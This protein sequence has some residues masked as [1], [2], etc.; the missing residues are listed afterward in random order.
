MPWETFWA[1]R[2]LRWAWEPLNSVVAW[3]LAVAFHAA[4]SRATQPAAW[5][6]PHPAWPIIT[7]NARGALHG[8]RCGGSCRCGHSAGAPT[9]PGLTD[10]P[11]ACL[12]VRMRAAVLG[13]STPTA[14]LCPRASRRCG[15]TLTRMAAAA[16]RSATCAASWRPRP[17]RCAPWARACVQLPRLPGCSQLRLT[18]SCCAARPPQ[19]GDRGAVGARLLG[20][21]RRRRPPAQERRAV[22]G[23]QLAGAGAQAPGQPADAAAARVLQRPVRRHHLLP[24]GRPQRL[25]PD[26]HGGAPQRRV[27]P[28]GADGVRAERARV[29]GWRGTRGARSG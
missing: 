14:T 24:P 15:A 12:R 22:R 20:A 3:W 1:L 18:P 6:L 21:A 7:A 28:L 11:P 2:A 4:F 5:R 10:G 23:A 16:S 9:T 19:A 13:R 26:G 8:A 25:P 27:A 17:T 29:Q